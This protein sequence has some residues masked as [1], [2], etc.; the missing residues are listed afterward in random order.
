MFI[1]E[2]NWKSYASI[3][4][5]PIMN[6]EIIYI[7]IVTF[8]RDQNVVSVPMDIIQLFSKL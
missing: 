4:I 7:K 2:F 5:V 8:A 3:I 6:D 1:T